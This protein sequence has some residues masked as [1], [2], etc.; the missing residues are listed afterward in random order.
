MPWNIKVT[1][2]IQAQMRNLYLEGAL[3]IDIA[4]RFGVSWSTAYRHV[5]PEYEKRKIQHQNIRR[6]RNFEA[7]IA[8]TAKE[9]AEWE[10]G[11]IS[12]LVDGEGTIYFSK[13]V[14]LPSKG[15]HIYLTKLKITNTAK[16]L[17]EKVKE[18]IGVGW[19]GEYPYVD[20]RGNRKAVYQYEVGHNV[21]RWL[22]PQL[23]LIVKRKQKELVL[24]ALAL[25]RE[26]SLVIDCSQQHQR[27]DEIKR[28][29]HELN[30]RGI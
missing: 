16:E 22:L 17:L 5:K 30:K 14:N 28:E 23:T 12:G 6:Q 8:K 21:M 19:I 29:M 27:L 7:R 2:E 11:W 20:K 1:P 15:F 25:L 26:S 18:I 10:R 4:R 9:L 3:I 13:S 24:E